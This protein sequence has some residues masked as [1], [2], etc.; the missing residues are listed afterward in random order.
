MKATIRADGFLLVSAETDLEAYALQRWAR[1]NLGADWFDATARQPQAKIILD[2][3]DWL[4]ITPSGPE[5]RA[6]V[7]T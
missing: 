6:K 2:W 3:S 4:V 1:E 7:P 5:L